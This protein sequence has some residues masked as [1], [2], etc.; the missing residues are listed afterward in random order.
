MAVEGWLRGT[1]GGWWVPIGWA[2]STNS[3]GTRIYGEGRRYRRG[4]YDVMIGG[5]EVLAVWVRGIDG[6]VTGYRR[7]R[8]EVLAGW[9]EVPPGW[10]EV[11]NGWVRLVAPQTPQDRPRLTS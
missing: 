5:C 4:G 11:L 9:C 7:G 6:A 2:T 10:Y 1:D 3:V 8:C